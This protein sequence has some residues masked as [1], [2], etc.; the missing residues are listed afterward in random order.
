MFRASDEP[1]TLVVKPLPETDRPPTFAGAVGDQFSIAV[2]TSRSVGTIS[3]KVPVIGYVARGLF[4]LDLR[5]VFPRQDE[6]VVKAVRAA[7]SR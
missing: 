1:R 2:K 5:T 6:D 4:K 7:V 3:S